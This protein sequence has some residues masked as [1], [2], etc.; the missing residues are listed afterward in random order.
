MSNNDEKLKSN[1]AL[2]YLFSDL[3]KTTTTLQLK[4]KVL[5]GSAPGAKSLRTH[6]ISEHIFYPFLY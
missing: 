2:E 5:F 4:L 3:L 6:S 1:Q